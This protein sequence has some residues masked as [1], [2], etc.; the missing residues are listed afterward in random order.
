M[1]KQHN[2]GHNTGHLAKTLSLLP[3]GVFL[4]GYLIVTLFGNYPQWQAEER[5]EVFQDYLSL[6]DPHLF[7]YSFVNPGN[8]RVSLTLHYRDGFQFTDKRYQRDNRDDIVERYK[9]I[10]LQAICS[11]PDFLLALQSHTWKNIDVNV[12]DGDMSRVT[13]YLFNLQIDSERC[14]Q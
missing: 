1:T 13:P 2:T 6:T 5:N 12:K 9:P 7:Y 10:V 3:A 11:Y 4:A 8:G 14:Q